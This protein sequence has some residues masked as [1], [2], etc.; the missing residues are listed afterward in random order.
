MSIDILF[1]V[2]IFVSVWWGAVNFVK[3]FY[4]EHI[5]FLNFIIMAAGF[6]G[7]ITHLLGVW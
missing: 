4:K 1:V 6:T 3:M 7:V 5:P 2:F